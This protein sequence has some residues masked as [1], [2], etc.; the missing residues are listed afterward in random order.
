MAIACGSS[1]APPVE[2]AQ[3]P[4]SS[5]SDVGVDAEREPPAAPPAAPDTTPDSPP[6]KRAAIGNTGTIRGVV[7]NA[8]NGRP[9]TGVT[10]FVRDP[11]GAV[12]SDTTSSKGEFELPSIPIGTHW[13]TFNYEAVDFRKQLT[14]EAASTTAISV[15]MNLKP[16]A[17]VIVK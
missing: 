12:V 16:R 5:P 15:T 8:A 1:P 13:V 3:E 17:P 11:D 10:V 4:S 9:L 6:A 7:T 2:H 14:V